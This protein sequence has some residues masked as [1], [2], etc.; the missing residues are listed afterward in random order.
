MFVYDTKKGHAFLHRV[1]G[2]DFTAKC[3]HCNR[4]QV[5][6]R[7]SRSRKLGGK[8]RTGDEENHDRTVENVFVYVKKKLQKLLQAIIARTEKASGLFTGQQASKSA[9]YS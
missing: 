7:N 2:D 8:F 1:Y 4:I 6:K 3:G 9:G 5:L